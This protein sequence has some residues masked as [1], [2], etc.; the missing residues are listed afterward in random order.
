MNMNKRKAT[1]VLGAMLAAN[2]GR[3]LERTRNRML[4]ALKIETAMREK[5]LSQKQFASLMDKSESEISDWLSGN[6]NFTVDTLT[7]I[8]RELG[9]SLLN[10]HLYGTL[11]VPLQI[12][13]KV[14][15]NTSQ[16]IRL[17]NTFFDIDARGNVSA[18]NE[19]LMVG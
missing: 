15:K 11:Q 4:I 6:R 18:S 12:A 14:K 13:Y 5:G 16:I 1:G 9:I 10:T 8:G 2:D 17:K 19:H 3:S 7:D